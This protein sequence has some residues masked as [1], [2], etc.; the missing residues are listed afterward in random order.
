M[1]RDM[2]IPEQAIEAAVRAVST[3][4]VMY[5]HQTV[6][7]DL[8]TV[9]KRWAVYDISK[10]SASGPPTEFD[11]VHSDKGDAYRRCNELNALAALSAAAPFMAPAG[12]KLVPVEPTREMVGAAFEARD[13]VG[14]DLTRAAEGGFSSGVM[15]IYGAM[16][17]AAPVIADERA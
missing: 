8:R 5:S 6:G 4:H 3:W 14:P 10:A 16:L 2:T 7:D 17:A 11:S 12:W 13:H 15:C 1:G 9:N